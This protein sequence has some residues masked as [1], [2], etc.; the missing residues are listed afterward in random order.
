MPIPPSAL[1]TAN[2]PLA[3][4]ASWWSA[5]AVVKDADTA[6]RVGDGQR[7]AG[8]GADVIAENDVAG[9]VC[10]RHPEAI[11]AIAGYDVARERVGAAD[12]VAA[13]PLN[14]ED[15]LIGVRRRVAAR[16]VQTQPAPGDG[17]V[18]GVGEF[19][20]QAIPIESPE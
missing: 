13:S 5:D 6:E 3:S 10:V 7:P 16:G 15:A 2:D 18:R 9:R 4:G 11:L 12:D 8:V 1:G 17:V 19:Q 20:R 14:K